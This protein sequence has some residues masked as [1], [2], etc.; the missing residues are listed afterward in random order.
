MNKRRW[1]L[2]GLV[3][4]LVFAGLV[5]YGD[6][7]QV[8]AL[9][10]RF[11]PGWL[12][13]AMGLAV[14]NYALRYARWMLYLGALGIRVAPRD[15]VPVF[16]AGLALSVT[17]GKV[18]ELLKCVWLNERADAPIARSAP[19]VVMERLTDVISISMLGLVGLAL[20]PLAISVVIG[21]VLALG[22]GAGWLAASRYGAAVL[23]LPVLRR[24][25]EPLAHSHDGLRRL[26]SPGML[27][28]G[29]SLGALAWASEGVALWLIVIGLGEHVPITVA[30]P[31]SAAAALVGA[32]TVLPGGLIGFEGSMVALLRQAGL[33]VA[34][35]ST[36]TLLTRL[37]TLWLAVLIGLLAWLWL[38][39]TKPAK[40]A[41]IAG[42][43]EP[44][45]TD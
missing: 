16:A 40:R 21:V 24:W 32:A 12:L 14:L 26:M 19:A 6:V 28:V 7:R 35:A 5:G 33:T 38:S 45:V 42:S 29:V 3:T 25:R 36:A 22:I 9:L 34:A 20:L 15:S 1:L 43:G 17:P 2:L 13:A 8:G 31:I 10:A 44:V 39:R 37:A 11:S 27:A 18:G 30:L 23:G 4:A 41:G